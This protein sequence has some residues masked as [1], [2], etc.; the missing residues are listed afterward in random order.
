MIKHWT[1][2]NWMR[3]M[4]HLITNNKCDK[5]SCFFFKFEEFEKEYNKSMSIY[6]KTW[7][8]NLHLSSYNCLWYLKSFGKLL[9]SSKLLSSIESYGMIQVTVIKA[10]M[11]HRGVSRNFLNFFVWTRKYRRGSFGI[12]LKKIS[13]L[14][15]IY[16]KTL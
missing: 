11:E 3:H 12:F 8:F 15:I 7:F 1:I 16:I 5:L 13:K 6:C 14:K 2:N 4:R 9:I 10:N